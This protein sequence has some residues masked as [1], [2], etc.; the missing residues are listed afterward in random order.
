MSLGGRRGERWSGPGSQRARPEPITDRPAFRSSMLTDA[1]SRAAETDGGRAGNPSGFMQSPLEFLRRAAARARA[2]MTMSG[3]ETNRSV[4]L[5]RGTAVLLWLGL[6]LAAC[7]SSGPAGALQ[8]DEPR[9]RELKRVLL[10]HSFGREFRP[11]SEYARSIKAELERQSPWPLD[12]QEHTLLSARFN[13]PGPEA[14]FVEYLQLA[15]SGPLARHRG[16]HWRTCR[17]IR[18]TIQGKAVSRHAD[19]DDRG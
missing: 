17:R 8:L 14:P 19:G 15:L 16:E 6:I 18:A 13:N 7:T 11:W 9:Y 3:N 1:S 2:G 12:V 5:W 10:L 4:K